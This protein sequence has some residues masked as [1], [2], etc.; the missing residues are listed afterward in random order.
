M[1]NSEM[2]LPERGS[3]MLDGAPTSTAPTRRK[4][5]S[6]SRSGSIEPQFYALLLEKSGLG[7]EDGLCPQMSREDWPAMQQKLEAIF[8]TRTRDE[9]DE[10][11]LGTDICYAP[12]LNFRD[13]IAHEHNAARDTF[14]EVDGIHQAAPAPRFSRTAPQTPAAAV[15]RG[16]IPTRSWVPSDSR[17]RKSHLYATAGRLQA[18][19]PPGPQL[20]PS[21][22]SS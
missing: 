6:S 18:D 5:G 1:M 15:T 7:E 8:K 19:F 20:A 11:M 9:W 2:W 12:V 10:I 14:V 21:R 22:S 4:T 16:R 3:N 17:M 13:A